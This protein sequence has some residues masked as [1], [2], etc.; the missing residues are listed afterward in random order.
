MCDRIWFAFPANKN[1]HLRAAWQVS[2]TEYISERLLP[3]EEVL[4]VAA[5]DPDLHAVLR[6]DLSVPTVARDR[7]GVAL[8]PQSPYD[9]KAAFRYVA[10]RLF[11]YLSIYI[12]KN[13]FVIVF[14]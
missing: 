2:Y 10:L 4:R 7:T 5:G 1:D 13:R 14:L 8:T 12:Y 11:I 6:Y 3:G 9:F